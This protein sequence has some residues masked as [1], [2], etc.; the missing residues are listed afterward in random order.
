L[1]RIGLFKGQRDSELQTMKAQLEQQRRIATNTGQP[2][3]Q[4]IENA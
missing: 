4:A 2:L 1:T 3:I